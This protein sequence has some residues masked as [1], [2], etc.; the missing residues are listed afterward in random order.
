M[1]RPDIDRFE[2]V[3]QTQIKSY[4]LHIIVISCRILHKTNMSRIIWIQAF[5]RC[6]LPFFSSWFCGICSLASGGIIT[7]SQSLLICSLAIFLH[8]FT[9]KTSIVLDVRAQLNSL[10]IMC[11]FVFYNWINNL[12]HITFDL[13]VKLFDPKI[14]TTYLMYGARLALFR[15]LSLYPIHTFKYVSEWNPIV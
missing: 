11:K 15:D 2:W 14:K 1:Y 8:V 7:L 13:M 12:H 10:T 5:R 9:K 3:V 6:F 4:H